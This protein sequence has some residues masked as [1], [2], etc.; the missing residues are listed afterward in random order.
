LLAGGCS[1][2]AIGGVPQN[3]FAEGVTSGIKGIWTTAQEARKRRRFILKMVI[4][5]RQARDTHRENSKTQRRFPTAG[6][7]HPRPRSGSGQTAS[8]PHSASHTQPHL[9]EVSKRH[10]LSHFYIKM[11]ILP[12]QARD[13]HREST[14]KSAVFFQLVD[15]PRQRHR[16]CE[17]RIS[18]AIFTYH[19]ENPP[20]KLPRQVRDKQEET[21]KKAFSACA[22]SVVNQPSPTGG[23]DVPAVV[24]KRLLEATFAFAS[25]HDHFAKTGSGRT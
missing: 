23:G 11:I 13:K 12:R 19:I 7:A 15:R 20:I 25:K 10:L 21:L 22:G 8:R 1:L 9:S 14:Q 3:I 6:D 5:P 17:K 2:I 24:R 16:G 18:R 4:L